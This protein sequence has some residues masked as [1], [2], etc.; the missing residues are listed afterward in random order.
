MSFKAGVAREK[1]TP[2]LGTVLY[3]YPDMRRAERVHDELYLTAYAF[4]GDVGRVIMISADICAHGEDEIIPLRKRISEATGVPENNITFSATHT[5]S[6]PCTRFSAGWGEKNTEF[7]EHTLNPAAIKASVRA[8]ES[9]ADAVMGVGAGESIVGTNRRERRLDGS[10]ALGQNPWGVFNKEMTVISFKKPTGEGIGCMINYGT[11]LT[12][13]G[14]TA[15]ITRD[16][17]GGMVDALERET[18]MICTFFA[19]PPGDTGPRLPNGKTT[20]NIEMMEELGELAGKDAIRIFNSITDYTEPRLSF[21]TDTLRIPYEPLMSY[22]AAREALDALLEKA[23][24]ESLFG[25]DKKAAKKYMDVIEHYEKKLPDEK[26]M[27]FEVTAIAIGEVAFCPF[28]FEVF[29]EIALRIA[30]HSPYKRTLV[31]NNTNGSRAYFPTRSE[32][33]VGG[34]EV[35]MFG[36]FQTYTPVSDSD[37]VAVNEYLRVLNLL[38]MNK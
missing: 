9:L 29:G 8:V 13:S 38:S 4:E 37:T 1:I 21:I 18:G 12:A 5:H 10:I 15:D 30:R 22:E 17:S 27:L 32:L 7:I 28:P 23:P 36:M 6:G 20:G 33:A 35:F 14:A 25:R 19:G 2:P 34:Y 31:L 16:W 24:Y 3:G 26:S 11:H